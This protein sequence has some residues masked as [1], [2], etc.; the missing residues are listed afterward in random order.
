MHLVEGIKMTELLK[1][2]FGVDKA[3]IGVVHLP[4]L[5][6]S[7]RYGGD[8][9][10]VVE[11]ALRDARAYKEGGMDG[12]II[13]NF[14]DVPYYPTKVPP[15]TV[16]AMTFVACKVS[17]VVDIPIG[18]NVL[19][20]DGVAAL[21]VASA[22]G[23]RFIRVNVLTEAVVTDQGIIE[24]IAHELLRFRR[25]IGAEN[26][27][28]F[29]DVHVKHGYPLLR[30][31]I[32]ESAIDTVYRGLA[33]AVIVSGKA[34]GAE[35]PLQDV[36]SVKDALGNVPVLVG[37]GV[38]ERNVAEYLKVCDGAIVGTSLKVNGIVENPVDVN[39]VRRLVKAAD[40][41]R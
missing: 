11:R 9:N 29:A 16:A 38:N 21:S 7:P 1:E 13:E 15:I 40:K 31:S 28:I 19:R 32:V 26:V 39:R 22:I 27:K 35:T 12:I 8:F 5:P 3:L 41:V 2:V 17:E 23:G 14:G 36:K 37:S 4:P 10:E 24:G 18:V 34:T 20:N 6:G 30:R 25:F 33:D